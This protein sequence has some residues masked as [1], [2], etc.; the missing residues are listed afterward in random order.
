MSK[1]FKQGISSLIG[2]YKKP[3][4]RGRKKTLPTPEKSTQEGLRPGYDRMTIIIDEGSKEKLRAIGW[5]LR[6]TMRSVAQ[7]MT[8]AY[9]SKFEKAH[10]DYEQIYKSYQERS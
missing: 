8:D 3:E 9:V 4:T 5:Y 6:T 10:P 1:D 7:D 2:D